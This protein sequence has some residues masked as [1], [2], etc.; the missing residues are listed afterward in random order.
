MT[1]LA[2]R[3]EA[4]GLF[5]GLPGEQ[6]EN[7]AGI[8]EERSFGRG[9]VIF[10]EGDEGDG[11]YVVLS[12]KVKVFKLSLDGKEQ[13]LHLFGPGDPLG[14]VPV[15]A[16]QS[17]PA[18]AETMTGAT[19]LFLPRKKL[20]ELYTNHPSLAMNMLAVLSGRLREFTRLIENLSLKEIPQRLAAYLL[21][22]PVEAPSGDRI[23]L[24]IPKG[25]LANILGTSQE[26]LSRVL[27]KMANQGLIRVNG[28]TIVLLDREGLEDLSVGELRL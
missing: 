7:L 14:E 18:N 20:L 23:V 11:F 3:L 1:D 22:Q 2:H 5:Q 15:F 24:Q 21:S 8:S 25:I 26:T 28:K 6:L 9:K 16:G 13:I 12:G 27:G 19:L 17:F 4:C 10:S